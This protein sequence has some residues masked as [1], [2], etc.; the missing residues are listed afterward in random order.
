M[1]FQVF[2]H[3]G[4]TSGAGAV[5]AGPD[6]VVTEA[7]PTGTEVAVAEASHLVQIVEVIVT[8]IVDVVKPVSTLVTPALVWVSVTG[9]IVVDCETMTVV[10]LLAPVADGVDTTPD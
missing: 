4:R 5:G 6:G 10:M 3:L 2:M 8:A 9:Q 1:K 7:D